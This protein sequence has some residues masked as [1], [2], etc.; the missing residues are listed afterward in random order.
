MS[1]SPHGKPLRG[2]DGLVSSPLFEGKFGR[3]FRNLP[4]LVLSDLTLQGIGNDIASGDANAKDGADLEES[5]IPAGYTYFGQ[6]I[7]HDITFDPA[8][9]LQKQNDP[10]ALV[11]Y[12]TPRFDLDNIYGRGPD[13]QAYLYE[14]KKFILGHKIKGSA[15][16]HNARDLPRSQPNQGGATRAIIG[17]PRNDEN[18]IVSQLQG[19]FHRFHN[20]LVNKFPDADFTE[21]QRLV[22]WHYQFVILNDFLPLIVDQSVI[23]RILPRR[24]NSPGDVESIQPKLLFFHYKNDPFIPIEFSAAAYRLGHSMVRPGYRLN[25]RDDTLLPI[26]NRADPSK[27]LNSFNKF[28]EHFALD[29][30]RF[31]PLLNQGESDPKDRIQ[32]AYKID[33]SLVDPL[34]HLPASIAGDGL[35]DDSP[36]V[37]LAY[38]NLARGQAMGLPSGES[39]AQSMGLNPLKPEEIFI[40]KGTS[41][42]ADQ[43][44]AFVLSVKYPE[45]LDNTPLWTYILAEG[46]KNFFDKGFARLGDVGGQ[47]VAEVFIGLLYGD[48]NS[49]VNVFPGWIPEI[50][51]G[52]NFDLT[53]MVKFALDAQL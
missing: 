52:A 44:A 32:F 40:G 50:G 46:R 11:D 19:I 23:D 27:G 47:I 3:M 37:S 8:S 17:D 29:W 20:A 33:T 43:A 22:R 2:V 51:K 35:P 12:R 39:V 5:H 34:K 4:S 31:L 10:D 45:T 41:D 42:P 16:N 13:D 49:F 48:G 21:I 6:F 1:S 28:N 15:R 53:D 18:I 26:F 24:V 36:L 30:A 7:D 38:R 14:G 25:E 9:S